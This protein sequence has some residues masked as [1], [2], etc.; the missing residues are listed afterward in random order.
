MNIDYMKII[1][2]VGISALIILL[3]FLLLQTMGM[4]AD[5]DI[6]GKEACKDKNIEMSTCLQIEFMGCQQAK[7]S[8]DER[9]YIEVKK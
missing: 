4:N 8:C 9:Q 7:F 6:L 5:L 3:G 1:F 2:I